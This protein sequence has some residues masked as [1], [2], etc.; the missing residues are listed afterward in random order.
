MSLTKLALLAAVGAILAVAPAHACDYSM[1]SDVTAEA[2]AEASPSPIAQAAVQPLTV[3]P[4]WTVG[5]T[6]DPAESAPAQTAKAETGSP[7]LR[8]TN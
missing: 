5:T 2:P 1:K 3:A 6:N 8:A 7:S 4:A